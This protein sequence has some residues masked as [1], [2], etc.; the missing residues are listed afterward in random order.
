MVEDQSV[1]RIARFLVLEPLGSGGMGDVYL[2][3]DTALERKVALKRPTFERV[4]EQDV[5]QVRERFMQEAKALARLSH[6][7][8]VQ[9]HEVGE[10]DGGPYIAMEYVRG[11]DVKTWVRTER[12]GWRR[13]V[14]RYIELGLGLAAAHDAGL[15]HRDIKPGNLLIGEDGRARVIDFGLARPPTMPREI[16]EDQRSELAGTPAFMAPELFAG[17][18]ATARSDQF[19]Y[20]VSLYRSLWGKHPFP[21][22]ALPS[23][24]MAI[25][26]V[27]LEVPPRGV[28][29]AVFRIIARGLSPEPEG[30]HPDMHHLVRALR[31]VT[32]ARRRAVA[33]V[34]VVVAGAFA[35][36]T[37]TA[38]DPRDCMDTAEELA[39]NWSD[40]RREELAAVFEGS[41]RPWA[42]TTWQGVEPELDGWA[43]AWRAARVRACEAPDEVWTRE[44]IDCL[45][46]YR[47]SF[48]QTLSVLDAGS[49][50]AIERAPSLMVELP[51]VSLCEDPERLHAQRPLPPDP[52]QTE[53]VSQLRTDLHY[54]RML[55]RAVLL[56]QADEVL[57]DARRIVAEQELSWGPLEVELDFEAARLR[58]DRAEDVRDTL[59][60][61]ANR[62]MACEHFALAGE[63]WLWLAVE[64]GRAGVEADLAHLFA[65][66][67]Q[68]LL[69]PD[70]PDHATVARAR[71]LAFVTQGRYEAAQEAFGRALMLGEQRWASDDPR[72]AKAL[73]D[74]ASAHLEHG[75]LEAAEADYRNALELLE[76]RL[77][78]GHP[79]TASARY[80]L[81]RIAIQRG[82]GLD[83]I[84]SELELIAELYIDRV[85]PDARALVALELARTELALR[86]G[87]LG[88]AQ[89]FA[90][91]AARRCADR[92]AP[93]ADC[94]HA[95]AALGTIEFWQ[96]DHV[97]AEREFA[98]AIEH[99]EAHGGAPEQVALQRSNRG[100]ALLA[101]GRV[102]EAMPELEQALAGL[103]ARPAGDPEDLAL[104]LKGLGQGHLERGEPE[105]AVV[106]LEEAL[107]LAGTDPVEQADIRFSL[108]RALEGLGREPARARMLAQAARETYVELGDE[109]RERVGT[110]DR[111]LR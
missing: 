106:A 1:A 85:V 78:A 53:V 48:E 80:G 10:D 2:A 76:A 52:Q 58:A 25:G 21:G 49:P 35:L 55:G 100:E 72:N 36:G 81:V 86:E 3:F 54:V 12:P 17:G 107:V 5:P 69:E 97:A 34:G 39:P 87:D 24:L 102:D 77:G 44:R 82:V 64:H 28:P 90:S 59:R 99:F 95:R 75:E 41:D 6:P 65:D 74:R 63:A 101:L 56:E 62:A 33:A 98:A 38:G 67:A 88:R 79:S 51:D 20:C 43:Q 46:E 94:G 108:A 110:I 104:P 22:T 89:R 71:G 30:R 14:E 57:A 47:R 66:Q 23:V 40:E 105:R 27:E 91:S 92:R 83:R 111:W 19:G 96:G 45:A 15:V 9:V 16:E 37:A 70:D 73:V 8:V 7:H 50:G 68:A 103:R 60:T 26:A 93:Q 31:R 29:R 13:I 109:W 61:I 11:A 84:G 4:S 18:P 42:R 32:R